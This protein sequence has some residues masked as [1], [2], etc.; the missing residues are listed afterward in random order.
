M[1]TV[2]PSVAADVDCEVR[3]ER[4]GGHGLGGEDGLR[5]P[6]AGDRR[7]SSTGWRGWRC[8]ASKAGMVVRFEIA[9]VR[10]T[11]SIATVRPEV[12]MTNAATGSATRNDDQ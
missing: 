8:S 9:R 7:A 6:P 10:A 4:L 3:F 12:S 5:C 11:S 2:H 1:H